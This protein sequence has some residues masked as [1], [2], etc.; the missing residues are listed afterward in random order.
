MQKYLK[1]ESE[2]PYHVPNIKDFDP[3]LAIQ[4]WKSQKFRRFNN[5]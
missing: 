1:A 4:V 5:E 2:G 3:I